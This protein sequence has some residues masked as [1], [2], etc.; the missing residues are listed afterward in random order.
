MDPTRENHFPGIHDLYTT[1]Q[2]WE[3]IY[4]K[5]PKFT[6]YRTFSSEGH[7][8]PGLDPVTRLSVSLEINKGCIEDVRLGVSEGAG[9]ELKQL[10][11]S[12]KDS[13]LGQRFWPSDVALALSELSDGLTGKRKSLYL[14]VCHCINLVFN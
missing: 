12:V 4:A 3:W 14:W 7:L 9:E 6:I 2:S 8:E 5:T 13:L 1:L 11:V 10:C